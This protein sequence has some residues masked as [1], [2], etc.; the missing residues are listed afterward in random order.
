MNFLNNK[1]F[2]TFKE[3]TKLEIY[4]LSTIWLQIIMESYDKQLKSNVKPDL[5]IKIEYLT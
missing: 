4:L 2:V 3:I 1:L 5:A